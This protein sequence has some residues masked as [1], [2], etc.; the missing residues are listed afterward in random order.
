MSFRLAAA[1]LPAIRWPNSVVPA[2]KVR[3]V[4]AFLRLLSRVWGAAPS[5]RGVA[6]TRPARS[7]TVAVTR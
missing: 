7:T 6:L 1:G 3:A 4:Y 5:S 2:R